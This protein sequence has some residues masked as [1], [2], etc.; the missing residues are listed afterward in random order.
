MNK[1]VIHFTVIIAI[2]ILHKNP[3][4]GIRIILTY[5]GIPLASPS[6]KDTFQMFIFLELSSEE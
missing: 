1:F 6:P 3:Q 4:E 2:I 5:I